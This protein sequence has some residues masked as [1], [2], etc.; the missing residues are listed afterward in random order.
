M[1]STTREEPHGLEAI[2]A[3][4]R[5]SLMAPFTTVRFHGWVGVTILKLEDNGKAR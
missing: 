3:E 2:V 5:C 1:A 4:L